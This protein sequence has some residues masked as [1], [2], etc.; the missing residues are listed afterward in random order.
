M[1]PKNYGYVT[2]HLY[3][4]NFPLTSVSCSD[5]Q[6][7]LMTKF[8]IDTISPMFPYVG[9]YSN[10]PWNSENC[11]KC[12]KLTN[13][14]DCNSIYIT[15]IDKCGLHKG[16]PHFDLSK[17]AFTE[18]FGIKGIKDG[19]GEVNWRSVDET[20]CKGPSK[21][22]QSSILDHSVPKF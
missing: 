7:G 18:L 21:H 2:Y 10:S 5:G 3:T 13:V 22:H 6:N 19:H 14:I 20:K 4:L 16:N 8:G 11:G 15:A 12:Y 17:E 9:A 1:F